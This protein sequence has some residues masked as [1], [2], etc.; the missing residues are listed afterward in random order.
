[1]ADTAAMVTPGADGEGTELNFTA[2]LEKW[3]CILR[4]Y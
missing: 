3:L 2:Q 4:E 1:M